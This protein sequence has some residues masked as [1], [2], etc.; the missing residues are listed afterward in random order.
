MVKAKEIE[1]DVERDVDLLRYAHLY[2][3]LQTDKEGQPDDEANKQEKPTI[4]GPEKMHPASTM[5][6]QETSNVLWGFDFDPEDPDKKPEKN[7]ID[8]D[9]EGQEESPTRADPAEFLSAIGT[10]TSVPRPM[11]LNSQ[12]LK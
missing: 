7:P 5:K 11:K 4:L 2:E 10:V 1:K 9:A 6:N 3:G 12:R 8:E